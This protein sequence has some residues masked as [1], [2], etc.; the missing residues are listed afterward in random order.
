LK[1]VYTIG[2][3]GSTLPMVL[4]I[5]KAND[6]TD[7]IDIRRYNWSALS[8]F[9]RR[10]LLSICGEYGI[11]YIEA[12]ELAPSVKISRQLKQDIKTAKKEKDRS[13]YR[14]AFL[15]Y[16][17]GYHGEVS[18]ENLHQVA[19]SLLDKNK[20][21]CLLGVKCCGMLELCPRKI[22]CDE[23]VN[24][25]PREYN[26]IHLN[27]WDFE[28]EK[29]R[30]WELWSGNVYD[31][32]ARFED[33]NTR[34]FSGVIKEDDILLL[35][36]KIPKTTKG[37][38]LG[39]CKAP[40]YIAVNSLLDCKAIPVEFLDSVIYHELIHYK[41]LRDGKNP[42]HTEEFYFEF[43]AFEEYGKIFGFRASEVMGVIRKLKT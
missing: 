3:E 2:Y 17:N 29:L 19:V 42:G 12:K 38:R 34:Y 36:E 14:E 6:V 26:F 21:S 32:F 11:T 40:N 7:L 1:N 27:E 25:H 22:L 39:Y 28:A 35:W 20:T 9:N 15:R 31:L 13:G 41:L 23:I 43:F 24:K 4:S 10:D 30:E 5:L 8:S 37:F 16:L 33:I 18:K